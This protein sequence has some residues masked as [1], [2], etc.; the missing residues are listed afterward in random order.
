MLIQNNPLL[1][2][3]ALQEPINAPLS[4]SV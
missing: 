1:P 4:V 3:E 2:H